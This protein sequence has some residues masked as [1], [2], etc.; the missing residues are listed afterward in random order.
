MINPANDTSKNYKCADIKIQAVV[1]DTTPPTKPIVTASNITNSSIT[2]T[3]S[4]TDN[5]GV[6]GY[7]IKTGDPVTKTYKDVIPGSPTGGASSGGIR[8]PSSQTNETHSGLLDN[9]EYFI[10]ITAYDAAGN[11]SVET[12][13]TAKTL[14]KD[15]DGDGFGDSLETR[16]TTNPLLKCGLNAWPVDLNNDKVV[17]NADIGLVTRYLDTAHDKYTPN[18]SGVYYRVRYDMNHDGKID[19][20]DQQKI[21]SVFGQKCT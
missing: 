7:S 5:V 16:M 15:S 12:E 9:T 10:G 3:W 13:A 2:W 21:A 11:K 17:N 19:I 6:V 8:P 1:A 20:T 4:A 14:L 18:S